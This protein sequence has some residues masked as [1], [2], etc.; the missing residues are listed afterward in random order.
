MEDRYKFTLVRPLSG[1][2]EALYMNGEFIVEGHIL[3]AIDVLN[4]IGSV[5]PNEVV[6]KS[7]TDEEAEKGMPYELSDIIFAE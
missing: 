2:W 5:L 6:F 1:D 7:V 4:A 3:R